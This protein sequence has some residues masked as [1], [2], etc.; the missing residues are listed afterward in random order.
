M[1]DERANI[2]VSREW[3]EKH[4]EQKDANQTWEEYLD[5]Q[6]PETLEAIEKKLDQIQSAQANTVSE[7][8]DI[9]EQT[10]TYQ[11]VK[12]ACERAIEEAQR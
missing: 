2:K 12:N 4:K 5:G 11:D 6:A 9:A 10:L 3:Y 1:T 7:S 8:L